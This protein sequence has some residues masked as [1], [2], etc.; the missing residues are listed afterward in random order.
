[1]ILLLAITVLSFALSWWHARPRLW[2]FSP[3]PFLTRRSPL[4]AIGL[5]LYGALE[6]FMSAMTFL[7]G[8]DSSHNGLVL[9]VLIPGAAVLG[10]FVVAYAEIV[11]AVAGVAFSMQA[12][13]SAATPGCG[14]ANFSG[15]VLI[16]VFCAAYFAT[17]ALCAPFATNR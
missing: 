14:Q 7:A 1:L 17:R 2:H 5:A 10:W 3:L 9:A 13:Y 6:I 15:V 8:N 12:I 4:P 11:V 16:A